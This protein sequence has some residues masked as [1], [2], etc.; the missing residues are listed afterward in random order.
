MFFSGKCGTALIAW[1]SCNL[2]YF[3]RGFNHFKKK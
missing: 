3:Q 1:A 2:C